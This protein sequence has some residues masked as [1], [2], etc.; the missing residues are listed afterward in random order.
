MSKINKKNPTVNS[1]QGQLGQLRILSETLSRSRLASLMGISFNGARDL[2]EVLGYKRELSFSDYYEVFKR[3]RLGARIITA[4]VTATW[5]GDVSVFENEEPGET[6]FEKAWK[7]LNEKCKL[8]PKLQ[9]LDSLAGIGR[10]AVLFM[11]FNDGLK[12]DQ[13]LEGTNKQLLYIQPYHEGNVTISVWETDITN[14]RYGLP[15]MY[16]LKFSVPGS[17]V[18]TNETQVHYTRILHIAEGTLENE[19]YGTPRLE[20]VYNGVGDL[21]KIAGGSAEMFWQGALGGKAFSA[22]DGATLDAQSAAAMQTEMDEFIHGLR[23]YMRL[24]NVDVQDLAPSL[25]DPSNY[26]SVQLDLI[27]GA[28]RIPKRILVG[29][30]R[31]ELASSQDETNWLSTIKER[32]TQYA[33]PYIIRSFVDKL[34]AVG[35]LPKPKEGYQVFWPDLWSASAKEKADVAKITTEALAA[36]VNAPGIDQVIPIEFYLEEIV[37][38][39]EEQI[40][41]IQTMLAENPPE[42]ELEEEEEGLTGNF[43]PNHDPESGEFT[44]GPGGGLVDRWGGTGGTFTKS[45]AK[46]RGEANA[47]KVFYEGIKKAQRT[48]GVYIS[49]E[50]ALSN[51]DSIKQVGLVEGSFGT[52]GAPSNFLSGDRARVWIQLPPYSKYAERIVPDMRYDSDARYSDLLT[53]HPLFKGADIGF[54]DA[55]PA[56]W[57]SHIEMVNSA[58]VVT[59]RQDFNL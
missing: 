26:V 10:F 43:N 21:E 22:K 55:I 4:P 7:A 32:R 52:L 2:Y 34:I 18:N 25:T 15:K 11:G 9:K 44:S 48:G 33:E 30:E 6:E 17:T 36:Y 16:A 41:R 50:T 59:S 38:L 19:I 8:T 51:I 42:E 45:P 20:D 35:A 27:A 53:Q 14:E 47:E 3:G 46:F 37:G 23:R 58:N 5:H 39:S 31:G 49:H 1:E 12:P 54:T 13:P 24:Q 40:E 56:S 28:K 29:S 57:I